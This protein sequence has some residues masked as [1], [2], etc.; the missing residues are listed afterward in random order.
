MSKN[1]AFSV[2]DG[3]IDM[4]RTRKVAKKSCP[5]DIYSPIPPPPNMLYSKL[6]YPLSKA[7]T[8][9]SS[10]LLNLRGRIVSANSRAIGKSGKVAP[11]ESS[12]VS[13]SSHFSV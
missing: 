9:S 11:A 4:V 1:S 7:N 5:D 6:S 10:Q 8:N 12:S 3:V 13:N 2:A